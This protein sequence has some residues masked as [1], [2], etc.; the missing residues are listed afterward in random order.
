MARYT[1][2]WSELWR[3][4]TELR[5][6][7]LTQLAKYLHSSKLDPEFDPDDPVYTLASGDPWLSLPQ[8]TDRQ[9]SLITVILSS[10]TVEFENTPLRSAAQTLAEHSE[11]ALDL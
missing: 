11:P 3:E 10:S 6:Q 4:S 1:D 8:L 5:D 2:R 7:E 9:L